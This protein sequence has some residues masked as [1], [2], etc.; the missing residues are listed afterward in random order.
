[1]DSGISF[2]DIILGNGVN[3]LADNNFSD[4]SEALGVAN[5]ND[6]PADG[7]YISLGMEGWIEIGF[8]NNLLVN[9]GDNESDL[10]VFE[11]GPAVE[12]TLISLRPF[13][14][15]TTDRLIAEGIT[16]PDGDG[17]YDIA[18]IGG[19]TSGLDIDF[20]LPNY[21]FAD[22]RFDAVRLQDIDG[23]CGV[24][25]PGA[26]IDAICALSG[27]QLDCAGIIFGTST[28]DDCGICLEPTDP[29]YNQA[30]TDCAGTINGT[31]ILDLCGDCY[32]LDD[33]AFNLACAKNKSVYIANIITPTAQDNNQ[34]SIQAEEG[35]IEDIITYAIYDRWG[36]LIFGIIDRP[37]P[38]EEMIWW[39]G[40]DFEQGVYTY[41]VE[42]QY[43]DGEKTQ[44]VG[45][46]TVIR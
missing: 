46:V 6:I 32:E 10:W 23:V 3:C 33:P 26:D 9:S 29:A 39:E 44:E 27:I 8:T 11:I 2:G 4:P 1:M 16:D 13:D 31:A 22:L 12:G 14:Q 41:R 28:I 37:T 40:R 34:F 18:T 15:T 19:A 43:Y 35:A 42:V 45:E 38:V 30:C 17:Y 21:I 7:K 5:Y 20:Y 25:T 24:T 36:N